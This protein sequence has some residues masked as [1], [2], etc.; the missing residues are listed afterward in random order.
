MDTIFTNHLLSWQKPFLRDQDLAV[1][2]PGKDTR[3]YDVVKYAL[4]KGVLIQ[5][6]RGL[7]LIGKPFGKGT[8]DPFEIASV[9]YGPSYISLETALSF[10]GWIPEAV[11][12]TT[13]VTPKRAKTFQ[14]YLG[15]FRFSHAPP[16]HFFLNVQRVEETNNGSSIFLIAEPWKAIADAIYCYRRDWK[17]LDD[18]SS[19]LRIEVETLEESDRN[20]LLHIAKYYD[21]K[22]VQKVLHMF[23]QELS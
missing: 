19:D 14:T 23:Y 9:L 21:C 20:S 7:Y 15:V 10:H 11:R 4:K 2:F 16:S 22:R 8:C 12:T 1:L 3:R 6:R 5:V 17:S 18:L 13:C